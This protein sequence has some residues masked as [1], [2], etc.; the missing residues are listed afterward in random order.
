MYPFH[1]SVRTVLS[2][3]IIFLTVCRSDT[4]VASVMI[5]MRIRPIPA[6]PLSSTATSIHIFPSAP[7]PRFPGLTPPRNTSSTSTMPL[8]RSRPWRTIAPLILCNKYQAVSYLL[9]PS[10]LARPRALTPCFCETRHQSAWNQSLSGI[11]LSPKTV[12]AVTE[13]SRR[14]FLHCKTSRRTAHMSVSVQWGHRGTPFQRTFATYCR[15][16]L[17]VEN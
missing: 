2:G 8:N 10:A 3:S 13:I 1:S 15:H 6:F 9:M 5:S 14:H 12:P 11:R 16:A 4:A 7:R 17:S